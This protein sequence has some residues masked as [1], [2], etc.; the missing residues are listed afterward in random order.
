MRSFSRSRLGLFLVLL[1]VFTAGLGMYTSLRGVARAVVPTH[2]WLSQRVAPPTASLQV[3]GGGFGASETVSVDFDT[4]QIGTATTDT[5]GKLTVQVMVPKTALPGTHTVQAAGQSSGL[6]AQALFLVQTD[7]SQFRF[8]PFHTGNNPYE[9]ALNRNNVS[10]LTLDW[11][12]T[13]AT[14][15]GIESSPAV[16]NGV[17]YIGS[18]DKKLYA[19]DAVTGTHKWSYTT[20]RGINSSP[21][22]ANGVVYV[23]SDDHNVY[24]F[25]LPG[26]S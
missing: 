15:N 22:V 20:G 2:I 12:Y 23:G 13:N 14:G 8:G 1:L 10:G 25:H 7:W 9:N 21:A 24:A 5:N 16:A 26:M 19:L 17:V 3:N 6:M 4:T 18:L 11:S